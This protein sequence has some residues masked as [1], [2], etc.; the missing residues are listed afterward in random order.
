MPALRL[1]DAPGGVYSTQ[2]TGDRSLAALC[3][4]REARE[5]SREHRFRGRGVMEESRVVISINGNEFEG[6]LDTRYAEIVDVPRDVIMQDNIGIARRLSNVRIVDWKPNREIPIDPRW[7]TSTVVDMCQAILETREFFNLEI[8]G[9]ALLDA[10]CDEERLLILCRERRVEVLAH[11]LPDRRPAVALLLFSEAIKRITEPFIEA[12][13]ILAVACAEAITP[14]ASALVEMVK[15]I[16]EFSVDVTSEG[17]NDWSKLRGCALRVFKH[18]NGQHLHFYYALHD[19]Q[20]RTRS[21]PA[22]WP[23]N[24]IRIIPARSPACRLPDL[25]RP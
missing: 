10:G 11:L 4:L 15:D 9:D 19:V 25:R 2:R 23:R 22:P 7:L 1:S 17:L 14:V 6:V 24:G 8:L 21:P 18:G 5:D 20:V 16:T 13:R 3:A 12:T